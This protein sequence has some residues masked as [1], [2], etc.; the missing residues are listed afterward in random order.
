MGHQPDPGL[1]QI[2]ILISWCD[3]QTQ[4]VSSNL[5]QLFSVDEDDKHV[6]QLLYFNISRRCYIGLEGELKGIW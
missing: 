5:L 6:G 3:V 2:L 1:A 4:T